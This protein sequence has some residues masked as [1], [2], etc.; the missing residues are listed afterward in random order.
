MLD[1]LK[2]VADRYEAVV[3]QLEDPAVYADSARLAK[4]TR[5]QKELTP[6]VEA[7][8]AYRQAGSDMEAARERLG[9]CELRERAQE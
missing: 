7:Y 6:L 9:D 1:K 4:L 8:S 3:S 5:E 2:A